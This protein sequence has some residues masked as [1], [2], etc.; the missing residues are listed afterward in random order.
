MIPV[1]E[2]QLEE[3]RRC[4]DKGL[5][6][7]LKWI[8]CALVL[9]AAAVV[10]LLLVVLFALQRTTTVSLG[11]QARRV[12]RAAC[13]GT[14]QSSWRAARVRRDGQFPGCVCRHQSERRDGG[15]RSL[16]TPG[17]PS[18]WPC[19]ATASP[20]R[21]APLS[22]VRWSRRSAS[23]SSW[24][25][26]RDPR[27]RPARSLSGPRWRW[28]STS[29]AQSSSALTWTHCDSRRRPTFTSI[30]PNPRASCSIRASISAS[31][32]CVRRQFDFPTRTTGRRR[33]R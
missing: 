11:A 6:H 13:S 5:W 32:G 12:P 7:A 9:L 1:V 23:D 29:R 26:Q 18:P 17:T 8:V 30:S 15:T 25:S 28:R 4:S 20:P 22:A 33:R 14:R 2:T 31:A 24:T 27:T 19:R 3:P 21:C 10:V 16:R